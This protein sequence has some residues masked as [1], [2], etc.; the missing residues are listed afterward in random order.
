VLLSFAPDNGARHFADA[1][2]DARVPLALHTLD[3]PALAA[4]YEKRHVLVRPDGHVAWRGD[5]LPSDPAALLATI[6]GRNNNDE[7]VSL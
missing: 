7:T 1:A 3:E 6:S 4:L 5:A 2:R